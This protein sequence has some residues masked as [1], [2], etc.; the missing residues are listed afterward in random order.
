MSKLGSDDKIALEV[1]KRPAAE[2]LPE[3]YLPFSMYAI[4]DRAL[5]S[6]DG[7]KPV[8]RRIIWSMFQK[9]I[10]HNSKHLKAA[11]AAAD[12]VAF[13]PHGSASVEAALARMAQGFALRVPLID[14]YGSVG[15]VTGDVAAA[16]R[17]WEARLSREAL[18]LVKEVK[19]GAVQLG[20]NFDGE[21][22]EPQVLPIR[23][24]VGIINGTEG[25]A[26]GYAS[27]MF[28]HNPD[29]VMD[30]CR[31]ILKNPNMRV[32]T[33]LK[34][35]P[36]PDLP[37]GGE[38]FGIDGVKEYYETGSGS[39]TIR[40]RYNIENMARGK[41]R[42]VFYEL[43]YQVSAEDVIGKIRDAQSGGQL[44]DIMKVQDLTDKKNGLRLVIETKAGTNHL[45]V[46]QQLFK[47]TNLETKFSV[48]N[49]VL[50]ENSPVQTSM[51]D[52][53][54]NF[55]EFRKACTLR[56]TETRMKA[57]DRRLAQLEAILAILIDIDKAIAIIRKS[58]TTED[59]RQ[60]LIKG[61][62]SKKFSMTE[63]QADYILAMQLRRLTKQ[64]SVAIQNE[65]K[66]LDAERQDLNDVLTNEERLIA[67]VDKDLVDA[68]KIIS[69]PRRTII[70]GMTVEDL[71]E[72][73]K[74]VAQA[75]RDVE[76]SLPC[77]VTRFADGRLLKS[78]EPFGYKGNERRYANSP[79]VEQIKMKTQDN[80]VL[81]GS[82]GVGRR[83]PLSYLTIGLVLTPEKAGVHLPKGVRLVGISKAVA[84]K[85]DVGVAMA[86]KTGGVKIAK[87]DFPK[88]DEFPVCLLDE[89]DEVVDSRWIGKTLTNT[90]FALAS[91]AGNILIFDASTIRVA[92]SKAGT[93]KGMKLKDAKDLVISFNW[94]QSVK[95][96]E[97][98]I[99]SQAETSIKLTP[100]SDIPTKNKG[101]MGV[102]LHGYTKGEKSLSNVFVGQKIILGLK[103]GNNAVQ[104]PAVSKRAAKG[105]VANLDLVTGSSEVFVY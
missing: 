35:M 59:A 34:T 48:N 87:T 29:E 83:I 14:P 77:Y 9:G 73:Q 69:S 43:P 41:V 4:R 63:E 94:I 13:H 68:K 20:K 6:D 36:G 78:D 66:E 32:D 40:A 91:K 84:M 26:V 16:A 44:K 38:L 60:A 70:S 45:A 23:W 33:L 74:Q 64:D 65:K 61:F 18:E 76:K 81:I 47:A 46:L 53:L 85:S 92:G 2:W 58:D 93:V 28:A 100:V 88:Q 30:A 39:F 98:F 101:G 25:I 7:L 79:V 3:Q 49:T 17:Y 55:V 22:D 50:I 51:I 104:L 11:R 8:N 24:P 42:I 27:K 71:K 95:D 96:P 99:F 103:R 52:L 86:T 75:A 5:V 56:R 10:L 97:T 54:R 21:L 19:E 31:K 15:V 80:I 102:A 72:A 12:A 57:I 62:S 105:V 1:I 90:W 67:V 82:D 37:T 89:G